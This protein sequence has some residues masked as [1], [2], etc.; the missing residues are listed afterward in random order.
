MGDRLTSL[1]FRQS[2]DDILE[3]K[4]SDGNYNPY[5]RDKAHINDKKDMLRLMI[6]LKKKGVSFPKGWLE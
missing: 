1:T 5:H 4:L 3:I 6:Q 2:S